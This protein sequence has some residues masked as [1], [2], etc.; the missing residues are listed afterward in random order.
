[1]QSG[2]PPPPPP[3]H[4][5]HVQFAQPASKPKKKVRIDVPPPP[6]PPTS[7]GSGV[8]PDGRSNRRQGFTPRPDP[9]GLDR[10]P[11]PVPVVG[12]DGFPL[13]PQPPP[14]HSFAMGSGGRPIWQGGGVAVTNPAPAEVIEPNTRLSNNAP[15]PRSSEGR[16]S[17]PRRRRQASPVRPPLRPRPLSSDSSD[18]ASLRAGS[19]SGSPRPSPPP[20]PPPPPPSADLPPKKRR[21]H[22]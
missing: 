9:D 8:G 13:T 20:P 17:T 15:T 21:R 11:P 2:P 4:Q 6:P 18:S 10:R 22:S 5:R 19:G 3:S 1:M 16:P 14:A 7:A 12:P